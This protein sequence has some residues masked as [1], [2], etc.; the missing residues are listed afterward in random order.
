[1]CVCISRQTSTDAHATIFN[2]YCSLSQCDFM[3]IGSYESGRKQPEIRWIWVTI[4]LSKT[5]SVFK[6]SVQWRHDARDGVSN[7]ELHYCF[8]NRLFKCRSKKTS[9]LRVTSLFASDREMRAS[10]AEKWFNLK[11]SINNNN[12]NNND[13][14]DKKRQHWHQLRW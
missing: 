2:V 7:R 14:Y 10:N 1:M 5:F 12:N 11:I 3:I 13:N 6:G 4:S 9:K 8:L